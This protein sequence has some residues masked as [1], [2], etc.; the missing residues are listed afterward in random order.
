[1]TTSNEERSPNRGR[2]RALAGAV[3]LLAVPLTVVWWPGCRE[4]SPV[5]SRE[6]LRLV[7]L[8]NSAC[9]TKDPKRLAEAERRLAEL[10]RHGKLS[11]GEK[12]GFEKI[13]GLAKAG[14]WADA[15][16][17]A[18]KMAQDQVGVGHPAPSEP[19]HKPAQ[20]AAGKPPR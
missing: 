17:A 4:Y 16:A 8:L 12:T 10:N 11:P 1:V 7:Q 9:N 15:E 20:A 13:V 5:T 2:L 14:S 19:A 6:S 18:F 3:L